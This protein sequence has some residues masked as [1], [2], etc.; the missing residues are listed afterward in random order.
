[1]KLS[2]FSG[3][4]WRVL[5]ILMLVNFVNY[6]DRQ[7][8]FALFPEIRHDFGLSYLQ[9]GYL[10]TAFTV[11]LSVASFPLGMLA[12][13][14]SR[15][16]VISAGVL[17]WSSATFLSGL[18]GSFR[19]LLMARGLVGIGEA[20]Y[21]PAG[22]AVISASFPREVRARVQGAFD[23]GMF[24]GGATGIALGGVV[25]AALGWRFAFFMVGIPGVALG[26]AALR[27]PRS[28]VSTAKESIPLRELL[29]V[30]AFRALLVSGWFCSFAGYAYVAWGP[31]LVEDYKGFTAGQAGLAL[32]LTIV[33]GGTLGIATGAHL[34]D[35]LAKLRSWGR[36]AV[37]PV[38]FVLAAPAIYFALHANGKIHFLL[39][40]TVGAFFLSW[41]H[42]PLTATIHD[43][44][45][46]RGHA[47]AVGFYYLF[48]NLFSMAIAPVVI[49]K[50][51]D[52]Y[53][54]ITALQV[55]ILAQLAGATSF[56]VVIRC[57]RRDGLHHPALARHR[58][59][60]DPRGLRRS[61]TVALQDG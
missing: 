25:A 6:V 48:V 40:F 17:F 41:Y 7:I 54:L 49:G 22:A 50:L 16:A 13:R 27:L 23:I 30:P 14:I 35:F 12:D 43:L 58:D 8:V 26:L 33:L 32:G 56:I 29:R 42:G 47:T 15:R 34:S 46:P 38:G 52:R 21:T 44:V 24:I 36:A 3:K 39:L 61:V 57:I 45:P 51:A 19:A 53:G 55:P 37:V 20:A 1:M 11:V 60:D 10:A 4:Q 2:D 18:A 31:E 5:S 59:D 9:L 28:V